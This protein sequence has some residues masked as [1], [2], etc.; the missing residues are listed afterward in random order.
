[1]ARIEM[2]TRTMDWTRVEVMTLNIE[3]AEVGY[4]TV[5]LS[6][7]KDTDTAL[8]HVKTLDTDTLKHVSITGIET[9]ATLYGMTVQ[10]FMKLAKPLPPRK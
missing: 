9:G 4:K 8:K 6:G 3:T 7:H 2:V 5:T 10:E 1:M